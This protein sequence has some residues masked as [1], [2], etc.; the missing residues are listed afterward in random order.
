[1]PRLTLVVG[2]IA[3]L[4]EATRLIGA[5][6]HGATRQI[7]RFDLA[8][9][10]DDELTLDN[11]RSDGEAHLSVY[12]D[13]LATRRRVDISHKAREMLGAVDLHPRRF[14]AAALTFFTGFPILTTRVPL[15]L[16]AISAF[17]SR[18]LART[19]SRSRS[20]AFAMCPPVARSISATDF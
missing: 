19:F 17:C 15:A 14:H 20:L 12:V 8:I 16:R 1:M 7:E 2:D 11:L 4:V 9:A 10:G 3:A 6:P 5:T 13:Y 18:A